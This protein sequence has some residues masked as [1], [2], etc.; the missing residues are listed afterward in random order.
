MKNNQ[1]TTLYE[2][3]V[4]LMEKGEDVAS[5]TTFK[6]VLNKI[7]ALMEKKP[8]SPDATVFLSIKARTY[9]CLAQVHSNIGDYALSSGYVQKAVEL[10]DELEYRNYD[11]NKIAKTYISLTFVENSTFDK[12][13]LFQ[14]GLKLVNDDDYLLKISIYKTYADYCQLDKNDTKTSLEY[15]TK[16]LPLK[17]ELPE[18]LKCGIYGDLGFAYG[19]EKQPKLAIQYMLLALNHNPTQNQKIQIYNDLSISYHDIEE[20]EKS[21][22]MSAMLINL[23]DAD[24]KDDIFE[25]YNNMLVC[26]NLAEKYDKVEK[27]FNEAMA[28][29]ENNG[30]IQAGYCINMSYAYMY[31]GEYKNG[32]EI[33]KKAISCTD[34][35][36]IQI[37]AYTNMASLYLNLGETRNVLRTV[38]TALEMNPSKL[39]QAQ[40]LAIK[41]N[42]YSN[43][44]S[45]SLAHECYQNA[46][47]VAQADDLP[48][49]EYIKAAMIEL[50]VDMYYHWLIDVSDNRAIEQLRANI[51]N[52]I[53]ELENSTDRINQLQQDERHY[54]YNTID[55]AKKGFE[56][57]AKLN[58]S[59]MIE[60]KDSE[61]FYKFLSKN[62]IKI[63]PD[64][65]I[66]AIKVWTLSPLEE[67]HKQGVISE[68]SANFSS[69][70][71][72][73][74]RL[75]E[76]YTTGIFWRYLD[77]VE[78]L[79]EYQ[80]DED[81]KQM[82]DSQ[83][84][85]IEAN[86]F[87]LADFTKLITP[88]DQ[89][90]NKQIDKK[91]VKFVKELPYGQDKSEK[92]LE[93]V[94]RNFEE[95]V[96]VCRKSR[97]NA[98][99]LSI[100]LDDENNIK[101]RNSNKTSLSNFMEISNIILFQKDSIMSQ[102][103]EMFGEFFETNP[104]IDKHS[105][106]TT[107][108]DFM[109]K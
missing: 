66:N 41:G 74:G 26:Y 85:S 28:V 52:E 35:E 43:E 6:K 12:E 61:K 10:L 62:N 13:E 96:N 22:E 82:I 101:P 75:L 98:F 103:Q 33:C 70:L 21:A 15:L 8:D 55:R 7:N 93:P 9:S 23:F 16:T 89:H 64:E 65:D 87:G 36:H 53:K 102:I 30:K 51:I 77:F 18:S 76:Y 91:F 48:F 58:I 79:P 27:V 34:D 17:D 57:K 4:R 47:K 92:E 49:A 24:D 104:N 44:N 25:A 32:I 46:L 19:L 38:S 78:T 54:I 31:K 100:E 68:K 59:Q 50:H 2:N 39:E 95:K 105:P 88:R 71:N 20:F 72:C 90:G 37:I 108:D 106:Q 99:H 14:K 67:L 83:R 84:E 45:Y 5:I 56:S 40:L 29:A 81:F 3:A 107:L 63:I 1:V 97:N 11:K 86:R 94:L 80:N 109:E 73:L 42:L 60:L 69:G